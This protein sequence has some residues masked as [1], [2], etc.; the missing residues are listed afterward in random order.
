MASTPHRRLTLLA[1]CLTAPSL[2]LAGAP[3]AVIRVDA[4]KSGGPVSRYLTG[5]CIEDVNHEIHGGVYSQMIFGE[6]FQEPPFQ[7]PLEGFVA[8][9]GSWVLQGETLLAGGG[10]GPKLVSDHAPFSAGEVG[11]EV[12]FADRAA[13]NAGLI[14]KTARPGLGADN[15]T[16]Y[17]VSLNPGRQSLHFCRHRHNWEPIKDAP[18]K[19]PVGAWVR[20][21]VK[22][23]ETSLEVLLDGKSILRFEDR[24]HPLRSG[25]FGLRQWQRAARYRNLRVKTTGPARAVPFKPKRDDTGPVSG[26]WRPLRSGSAKGRCSL[27]TKRPFVGAQAQRVDFLE[28]E[29]EFG[30]ENQGLNRWGLSFVAGKPYE[31]YLW[32]RAEKPAELVVALESRDGRKPYAQAALPVADKDWRR[33]GF[34]LTPRGAD[35]GGRFAVKLKKAGSVVLGHAFLQPGRWGRFKGLPLRRDV[36]EALIDQGLTVLRYG[37][38][39]VNCPEYRWKKM[40]GPRDTRPPY[41][42]T[43]YPYSSNG[44]GIVDFLNLCEAAGFL[45]IP[46]FNIDET[47]ADMADFVAYA[48]GPAGGAWGKKRSADGH[49]APYRLTHLQLGNEERIDEGYYRR[50]EAIAKAVWAVDPRVILVVGDFAYTQPITDP[51]RV[52]GAVSGVRSLEAHGRILDLARRHRREVW[53]DIHIGTEHPGALAELAVVPSY[54]N[55]LA[56]RARGARHKVVVFELNAGNHAHRRA[57]ANAIAIGELQKLGERLPVVCSANALQPDGQNDNG[58]DQ[59]LLFLDP[60][61]V[62]LQPP[63]HVTRMIARGYQPINVP[64]EVRGADALRVS[65]ARSKDG[66]TLVLRVVNPGERPETARLDFR[67]F[68]PVLKHVSVEVLEGPLDAVNTAREPRRHAPRSERWTR[69]PERTFAARSFQVLTFK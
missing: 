36:V 40:I 42:G 10:P 38:S 15:F 66:K 11:V 58:W 45:A 50:F 62:W 56:K 63:G 24:Q 17:E 49:P 28:G 32:A 61:R 48:N 44:W 46:A 33:Y 64:V 18:C 7:R 25:T 21:A 1:A 22:M 29:G 2:A 20:L 4:G 41:K 65:A 34:A 54:V 51:M 35:P 67:G 39:M 6:S 16:G 27:E 12:F 69:A 43:W 19:I 52:K 47:P 23:G 60:S 26:M 57:L 53:F 59:G 30:V 13:G 14:V 5:A 3:K 37:G 8:H 55:A 9:G 31:G 68:E